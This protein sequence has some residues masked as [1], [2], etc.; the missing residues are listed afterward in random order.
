MKS[1]FR[2]L[3][4]GLMLL[5]GC[6][7]ALGVDD[8]SFGSGGGDG[9]GGG[10]EDGPGPQ[11]AASSAVSVTSGSTA[12]SSVAASSAGAGGGGGPAVCGDKITTPPEACDDG[13]SQEF[14]ACTPDCSCG[15]NTEEAFAYI[16]EGNKHCYVF[17]GTPASAADATQACAAGGM[18]LASVADTM[19]LGLLGEFSAG[20]PVWLGGSD[21]KVEGTWEWQSGEPWTIS[22]CLP[23]EPACQSGLD[24]WDAGEPSGG[25]GEDC[26]GMAGGE[27]VDEVCT[28]SQLYVCEK[29]VGP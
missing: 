2:A 14:D 21:A 8:L 6:R 20:G 11:S 15:L 26:L 16:E 24:F 3:G 17:V 5:A 10:G 22:P 23:S 4:L 1:F 7:E 18:Y 9:G 28:M 29:V 27:L 13:N 25:P 12:A 19:E